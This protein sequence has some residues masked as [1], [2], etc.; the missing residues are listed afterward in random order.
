M[1][2]DSTEG[3]AKLERKLTLFDSMMIVVTGIV[4]SSIFI[5]PADVLRALP[6]PLVALLLWVA[7]G[8]IT[9][10]AGLACAE[11][12]AMYPEAG[13]QYVFIR[14]AYGKFAAFLY[15][16][17]LF[18]ACNSG[19]LAAMAISTAIFFG[20]AFPQFSADHV[21]ISVSLL[22]PMAEPKTP[23]TEI[24]TIQTRQPNTPFG[25]SRSSTA[26]L[27]RFGL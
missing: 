14:E 21:A 9:L 12:G 11:L 3:E 10:V 18:T 19:A 17:V 27:R 5:V 23:I 7:A 13:G 24:T 6:N 4:G 15:G 16:W 22:K 1:R 8:G 2:I 25:M 26:S 20:R